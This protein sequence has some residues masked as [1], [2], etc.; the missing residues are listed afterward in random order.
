MKMWKVWRNEVR[1][2]IEHSSAPHV[3]SSRSLGPSLNPLEAFRRVFPTVSIQ[4]RSTGERRVVVL[5][6]DDMVDVAGPWTT[7]DDLSEYLFRLARDTGGKRR[8]PK[9]EN[10]PSPTRAVRRAEDGAR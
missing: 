7:E 6:V 2:R 5:N 8:P 3:R 10:A 9:R 4:G 1:E